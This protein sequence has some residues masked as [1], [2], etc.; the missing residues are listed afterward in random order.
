M[1]VAILLLNADIPLHTTVVPV[2]EFLP[3]AGATQKQQHFSADGLGQ[4]LEGWLSGL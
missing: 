2:H 1:N 3:S 4:R